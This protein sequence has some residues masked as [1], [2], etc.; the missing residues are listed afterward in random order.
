[1][2]SKNSI[3]SAAITAVVT[4]LL[5]LFVYSSFF[6]AAPAPVPTLPLEE[7]GEGLGAA[8]G[9]V[10]ES[11]YTFK[12]GLSLGGD[13]VAFTVNGAIEARANQA[14]WRNTKGRTVYIDKASLGFTSGTAST[15]LVVYA[16]TSSTATIANDY[17]R[18]GGLYRLL[19]GAQIPTS[20]P[21]TRIFTSTTTPDGATTVI[22]VLAGEYV[23]FQIQSKNGPLCNGAACEAATS[24]NRGISSF[25]WTLKGFYRP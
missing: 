22:P 7:A 5:V 20:T 15:S 1:M 3:V 11:Q 21:A 6:A 18:P 19:D 12:T 8:S 25:P 2:E 14:S 16:A 17:A 10:I 13:F 23:V 9:P 24:T 4:C